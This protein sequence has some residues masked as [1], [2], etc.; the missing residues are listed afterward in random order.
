MCNLYN[1]N[2]SCGCSVATAV[3][4]RVLCLL[5]GNSCYQYNGNGCQ[6]SAS[7]QNSSNGCC[8][9][10]NSGCQRICRDAC[11]C[12]HVNQNTCCCNGSGISSNTGTSTG[13]SISGCGC[14]RCRSNYCAS[15]QALSSYSG[16]AYYARLYGL[17]GGC[18]CC[19]YGYNTTTTTQ[20]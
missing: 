9:F 20:S 7:T 13:S 17:N 14:N 15:T 8:S 12:I 4:N 19:G 1:T 5:F 11:G 2:N 3:G 18:G 16:D 10:W 6:N